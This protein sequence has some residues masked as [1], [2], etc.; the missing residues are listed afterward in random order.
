V[1]GTSASEA[2]SWQ[3]EYET[4]STPRLTC[5]LKTVRTCRR[6]EEKM[7]MALLPPLVDDVAEHLPNKARDQG[8]HSSRRYVAEHL[9]ALSAL[10][11]AQGW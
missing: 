11:V 2:S 1:G 7:M 8:E 3:I 10:G 6:A 9:D 4:M 5:T